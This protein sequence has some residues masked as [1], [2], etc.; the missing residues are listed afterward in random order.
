MAKA[1]SKAAPKVAKK[2]SAKPAST[3]STKSIEIDK[4]ADLALAKL[5]ELNLD[6]PLQGE[7]EWCIG[8]YSF[9]KNP[10][11]LIKMISKAITVFNEEKAKKTKGVTPKLISDLSGAIKK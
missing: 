9:D 1:T 5:K 10:E 4:A 11:G 3:T 2:T 7:L 8:S 6:A